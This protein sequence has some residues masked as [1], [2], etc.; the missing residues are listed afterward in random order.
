MDPL[1]SIPVEKVDADV[2]LGMKEKPVLTDQEVNDSR[3]Q[4]R[5]VSTRGMMYVDDQ[6]CLAIVCLAIYL[7]VR[8]HATEGVVGRLEKCGLS[9]KAVH[10][11][12]VYRVVQN[13]IGQLCDCVQGG[14]RPTPARV[15][16]LDRYMKE[17]LVKVQT[18]EVTA[19]E[20][21]APYSLGLWVGIGA[22][23]LK[24]FIHG[25]KTP[26]S[27]FDTGPMNKDDPVVPNR[28]GLLTGD[29]W[30]ELEDHVRSLIALIA[31]RRK[32]PWM[33]SMVQ[34]LEV[35][36]RLVEKSAN[37]VMVETDACIWGAGGVN[38][39]LKQF[40]RI[41]HP[42]WVRKEM[43]HAMDNGLDQ[44]AAKYYTMALME[45]AAVFV[46]HFLWAGRTYVAEQG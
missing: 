2:V 6:I 13:L 12:M 42:E 14:W 43:R 15:G 37:S 19:G 29:A 4:K 8:S 35:A 11:E 46:S 36:E 28:K 1:I 38:E 23:W 34:M 40:F 24:A 39:R 21:Y 33:T 44:Q 27:G 7:S 5:V 31:L 26:L 17:Y 18:R 45:L 32:L 16:K 41:V 9:M 10:T 25:L 30:V 3:A 20:A 22:W